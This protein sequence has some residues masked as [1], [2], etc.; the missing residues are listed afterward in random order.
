MKKY[1]PKCILDL[2]YFFKG[3]SFLK[4]KI[5]ALCFVEVWYLYC[6]FFLLRVSEE[7]EEKII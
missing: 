1:W 4:E 3:L 6:N 7:L 2:T 5:E